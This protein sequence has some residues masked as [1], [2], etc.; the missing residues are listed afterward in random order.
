M[1]NW[2]RTILQQIQS[3]NHPSYVLRDYFK[4]I[5]TGLGIPKGEHY[6]ANEVLEVARMFQN[7][8]REGDPVHPDGFII[9]G[10]SFVNGRARLQGSDLDSVIYSPPLDKIANE[11]PDLFRSPIVGEAYAKIIERLNKELDQSK[12]AVFR[13][14]G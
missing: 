10:G 6:S 1:G 14:R 13:S 12:W 8:L 2:R 7:G 11:E 4:S 5:Q 3:G 9:L